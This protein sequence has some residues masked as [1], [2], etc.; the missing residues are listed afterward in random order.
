MEY[1]SQR[2]LAMS[3][4]ENPPG[5][6]ISGISKIRTPRGGLDRMDE[7]A[8]HLVEHNQMSMNSALCPPSSVGKQ[9]ARGF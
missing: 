8:G 7:R 5:I 3:F 9:Q 4:P 6:R 1:S 2:T